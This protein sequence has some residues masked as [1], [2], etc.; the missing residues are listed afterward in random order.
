MFVWLAVR[1][2]EEVAEHSVRNM[3]RG[4]TTS[5]ARRVILVY[6]TLAG[7]FTLF[8]L[9]PGNPEYSSVWGFVGA[10]GIQTLVVCRLWHGSPLA[11]LFGF[12]TT[13]LT[14][15]SLYLTAAPLEIGSIVLIVVSLAQ[16]S[17]L[18]SP[19]LLTLVWARS[20]KPVASL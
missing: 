13:L 6:A 5:P 15:V 10:I 19:S 8:V 20:N 2:P 4:V 17:M 18:A 16:A 11:W 3:L 1:Q 14:V 7:L 9:L 12:L